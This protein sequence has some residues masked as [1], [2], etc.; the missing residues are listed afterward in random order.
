MVTRLQFSIALTQLYGTSLPVSSLVTVA[1]A[2]CCVISCHLLRMVDFSKRL[3]PLP[4]LRCACCFAVLYL[5]IVRHLA[6]KVRFY[7]LLTG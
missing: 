1:N 3:S 6:A 4:A 2:I 7:P 5:P